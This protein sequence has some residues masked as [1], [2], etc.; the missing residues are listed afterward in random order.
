M[1]NSNIQQAYSVIIK[2]K[3][4]CQEVSVAVFTLQRM[5]IYN[6]NQQIECVLSVCKVTD[7]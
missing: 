1:R 3:K 4:S 2:K 5:C 6:A 7:N